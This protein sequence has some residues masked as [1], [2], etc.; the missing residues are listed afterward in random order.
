MDETTIVWTSHPARARPAG[1]MAALLCVATIGVLI[2]QLTGEWLWGALSMVGLFL[3]LAR[4]FLPT[5]FRVTPERVEAS[6]PLASSSMAW[7]DVHCIYWRESRALIARG[8]TARARARGIALDL[9]GLDESGREALREFLQ[10][11]I[12]KEAWR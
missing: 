10:L 1:A 8:D 2:A 9:T 5:R 3:S 6:H 11:R 4:F 7:A 12:A